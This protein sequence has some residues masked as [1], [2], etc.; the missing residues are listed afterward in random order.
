MPANGQPITRSVRVLGIKLTYYEWR[1]KPGNQEPPIVIAHATGFHGRCYSAIAEAFPDRRVI[2][3]DLHGHGQSEGEPIDDWRTISD[4]VCAFLDQIRI[5]RA[6]GVGH[7]MGAHT[8]LQCA[9]ERPEAFSRLVLFDPVILPPE[10]YA[11]SSALFT[12]DAPH[13]TIRRKR[14]FTSIEAMKERFATR[15][16]YNLFEPRVFDDY[17]RFGVVEQPNGSVE[18]ACKPE[19]EASVYSASRSNATIHETASNAPAQLRDLVVVATR[20]ARIVLRLA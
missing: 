10:Y 16:P 13:P 19:M 7:S 18:L 8:L 11:D 6:I 5:R 1:A 3:L 14:D 9:S 12:S 2:S 4:E 15:D 20:S 17:C